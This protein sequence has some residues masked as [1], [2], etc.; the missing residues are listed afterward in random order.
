MIRSLTYYVGGVVV[1]VVCCAAGAF[2]LARLWQ[3]YTQGC[4]CV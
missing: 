4:V 3:L 2:V 1:I